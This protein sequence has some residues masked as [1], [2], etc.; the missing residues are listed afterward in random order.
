MGPLL[1][2]NPAL[3]TC[4]AMKQPSK[5]PLTQMHLD[6]GQVPREVIYGAWAWTTGMNVVDLTDSLQADFTFSTCSACGMLYAKGQDDDEKLHATF[7]S[8]CTQGVNFQARGNASTLRE[9]SAAPLWPAFDD[10]KSLCRD[11][12]RKGC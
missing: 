5:K 8:S 3:Q 2:M 12:R 11:G 10:L 6:F 7:H 1:G 4:S 9:R